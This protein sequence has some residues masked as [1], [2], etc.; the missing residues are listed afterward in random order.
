MSE[1]Q[2][3]F[4]NK[5]STI[6]NLIELLNDITKQLDNRNNVDLISIDFSKAFDTISHN[7][8]IYKL[9]KYYIDKKTLRWVKEF[10]NNRT[11]SVC[12]NYAHSDNFPVD[13][14]VPQRTKLGP[15][16]YTLFANDIVKLFK[17]VEIKMYAD[18][19]SIY[20]VVKT[21]ADKISVQN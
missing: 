9:P 18:D 16:I 12:I 13:S 14:S 4:R 1:A 11:F 3:G 21:L 20:A 5:H 2:H 15:L 8:L 10:L 7:K 19:I 6:T 17:F